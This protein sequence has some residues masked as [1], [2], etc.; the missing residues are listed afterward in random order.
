MKLAL[1]AAASASLLAGSVSAAPTPRDLH[2]SGRVVSIAA[3]GGTVAVHVLVSQSA[4]ASCDAGS[5]WTP[6][7]GAVVALRDAPCGSAGASDLEYQAIA[8]AGKVAVWSD[9]DF[10]NHAY[11]SG[12]YT[13]TAAKPA[14]VDLGNCTEEDSGVFWRYAGSG[15]LLVASRWLRCAFDCGP[16]YNF[17]G[18]VDVRLFRVRAGSLARIASLPDNATFQDADAGRILLRL[19]SGALRVLDPAGITLAEFPAHAGTAVLGG[20]QWVAVLKGTSVFVYDE[21]TGRPAATYRVPARSRLPDAEGATLAYL[22]PREIHL[23]DLATG[24]DRVAVRQEG[25]VGADLEPGGIFSAWNDSGD[26]SRP[27]HLGFTALP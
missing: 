27:G 10:G 3:D 21:R 6:A 18:D 1:A 17:A 13:A 7:S 5:L 11:C 8:L 24:R 4:F 9:Y 25:L 26:K 12:P 23:L 22:A 20:T 19:H 16:G 15:G 2:L 14:P